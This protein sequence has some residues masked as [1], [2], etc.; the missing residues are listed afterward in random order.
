MPLFCLISKVFLSAH[1]SLSVND[2][3]GWFNLLLFVKK[4]WLIVQLQVA[5]FSKIWKRQKGERVFLKLFVVISGDWIMHDAVFHKKR[6]LLNTLKVFFSFGLKLLGIVH[7]IIISCK[8]KCSITL[9]VLCIAETWKS[10]I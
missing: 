2:V 1:A 3:N 6:N 9:N 7:V 8:K 10:A 5:F 4:V